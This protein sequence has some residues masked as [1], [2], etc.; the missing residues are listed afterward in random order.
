M[1]C[2][3]ATKL[4]SSNFKVHKSISKVPESIKLREKAKAHSPIKIYSPRAGA[5]EAKLGTPEGKGF[6]QCSLFELKGGSR[7]RSDFFLRK[8]LQ[9]KNMQTL[10][11]QWKN[12][13]H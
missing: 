9:G 3:S 11:S 1:L 8:A 7:V 4:I 12:S 13:F 10:K 5:R 6:M 2:E